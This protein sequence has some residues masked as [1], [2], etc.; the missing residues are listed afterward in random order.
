MLSCFILKYCFPTLIYLIL[1]GLE[2]LDLN[3]VYIKAFD[4]SMEKSFTSSTKEERSPLFCIVLSINKVAEGIM[5]LKQVFFLI[6]PHLRTFVILPVLL[7][8]LFATVFFL[9]ENDIIEPN[10]TNYDDDVVV[11][12]TEFGVIRGSIQRTPSTGRDFLS[13]TGIPYGTIPARFSPA[14]LRKNLTSAK[15][16]S[17]QSIFDATLPQKACVQQPLLPFLSGDF[18]EDCLTL[19]IY[20]PMKDV[21]PKYQI[22]MKMSI[23]WNYL[24]HGVKNWHEWRCELIVQVWKNNK[25]GLPVI[26]FVHGIIT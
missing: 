9:R 2:H 7:H 5:Y 3:F 18:T 8:L 21:R 12:I 1:Q 19:S 14:V 10:T 4:S 6:S 23:I 22:N 11:N 25:V 13:F 26:V 20:T 24:K 16:E 15:E 17:G